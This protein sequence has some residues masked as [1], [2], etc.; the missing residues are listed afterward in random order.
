MKVPTWLT[1]YGDTSFRGDCPPEQQE[2]VTFFNTLRSEF[3]DTLGLLA[4]HPR[5]EGKR[6]WRQVQRERVEGMAVGAS[7]IIIPGC[8]SFVCEL[9][10]RDHTKCRLSKEEAAYL[11]AAKDAGAFVCLALGWKAAMEAIA[12]WKRIGDLRGL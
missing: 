7:D 2:Q 9:K 3:P 6:D 4:L 10:R 1:V 11:A 12:V 5:N 8:H